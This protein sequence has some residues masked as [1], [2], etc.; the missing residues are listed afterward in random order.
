MALWKNKSCSALSC[1]VPCFPEPGT[2]R[3]VSNVCCVYS[4]VL[5]WLVYPS[6]QSSAGTLFIV[7]SV[8][9]WSEC[10]AFYLD[11]LDVLWSA[12]ET[13]PVSTATGT[14]APQNSQVRRHCVSRDLDQSSRGESLPSSDP[15]KWD[16]KGWFH[17]SAEWDGEGSWYKQVR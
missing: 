4:P 8:G 2:S 15:G 9:S 7:D 13:R 17:W 5:S 16:W 11:V 1:R 14:K 10:G 3:S 6:G 12:S